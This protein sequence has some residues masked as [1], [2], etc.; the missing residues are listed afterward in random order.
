MNIRPPGPKP[1]TIPPEN[2]DSDL[3][4]SRGTPS[5]APS[6]VEGGP[7]ERETERTL[8]A[9]LSDL[10][11]DLRKVGSAEAAIETLVARLNHSLPSVLTKEGHEQLRTFVRQ[12]MADDPAIHALLKDLQRSY[13]NRG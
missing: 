2:Q 5:S 8:P 11:R 12:V 9:V 1:P 10:A 7:R 13:E 6:R 4:V 3:A